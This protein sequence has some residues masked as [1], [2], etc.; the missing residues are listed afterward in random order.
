MLVQFKLNSSN[1]DAIN[2][3]VIFSQRSHLFVFGV[4]LKQQPMHK[5]FLFTNLSILTN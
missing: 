1:Y 4:A 3:N 2:N 5:Q